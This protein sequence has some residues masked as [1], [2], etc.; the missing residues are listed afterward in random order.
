MMFSGLCIA[1]AFLSASGCLGQ[2]FM[3]PAAD[4]FT[5]N[6]P[7]HILLS[8]LSSGVLSHSPRGSALGSL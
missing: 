5:A 7:E 2:F 3:L 6:S 1:L 4:R 8:N